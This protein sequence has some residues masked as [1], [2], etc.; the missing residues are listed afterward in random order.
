MRADRYETKI[1]GRRWLSSG[2]FE[3]ELSRP[4]FF[5]F[6][7]GQFVRL[8]HGRVER[9]YTVISAPDDE[10]LE[11]CIAKL[12]GEMPSYLAEADVGAPVQLAGPGGHFVYRESDRLSVFVATGVGIAPFVS[13][14][15]A[16]VSNYVLLHGVRCSEDLLYAD[17][18]R[19]PAARYVPCLSRPATGQG[20]SGE[21]YG[22]RVTD[23]LAE[24]L[25]PGV[26]DFYLC[27]GSDMIVNALRI[28]DERYPDS[29]VFTEPFF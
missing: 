24:E 26:Y 13:Y 25:E 11:F 2:V 5:E 23:Y 9:V 4:A 12:G 3:L 20:S 17:V 21:P 6:T 7:P 8:G 19:P 29:L 1:C 10:A 27:G 18:V 28:V 14:A 15:R 22:G 16:G